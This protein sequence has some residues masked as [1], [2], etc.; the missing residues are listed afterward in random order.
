MTFSDLRFMT[1]VDPDQA[2]QGFMTMDQRVNSS[3]SVTN[4]WF[5]ASLFTAFGVMALVL[6]MLGVYGP[7]DRAAGRVKPPPRRRSQQPSVQDPDR[8]VQSRGKGHPGRIGDEQQ[9]RHTIAAPRRHG[10]G[11]DDDEQQE[12]D[13]QRGPD[14]MHREED[15]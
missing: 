4:S 10:K 8:H 1:E 15:R 9:G 7:H 14:R 13:G 3:P 5:F 11:Q 12:D 6:A 2:P